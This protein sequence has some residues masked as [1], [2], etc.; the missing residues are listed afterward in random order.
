MA[1][2][3]AKD[4]FATYNILEQNAGKRQTSHEFQA[5]A[6]KLAHE[7]ND[8]DNLRMYMRLAKT[9]D[10]SI[11]ERAFSFAVDSQNDNRGKVFMWKVGD[12]RKLLKK[13]S[14][15][16]NFEYDYVFQKSKKVRDPIAKEILSSYKSS[17]SILWEMAKDFIAEK[18]KVLISGLPSVELHLRSKEKAK[19]VYSH[20]IS[21]HV[22]SAVKENFKPR[23]IST[24]HGDLFNTKLAKGILDSIVVDSTWGMIPYDYETKFLGFLSDLL[25]E[26]GILLLFNKIEQ[27]LQEWREIEIGGKKHMF[28]HKRR[29]TQDILSR[30]ESLRFKAGSMKCGDSYDLILARK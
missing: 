24:F 12:I 28:F 19:K 2:L 6:Y 1:I 7:L 15:M 23:E 20:D 3:L 30:L 29:D 21:K 8:L 11:I 17:K 9:V 18:S 4:I 27:P 14:E 26:T 10:R 22:T 16:N 25:N 5:F 13:K